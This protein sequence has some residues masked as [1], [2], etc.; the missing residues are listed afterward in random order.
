MVEGGYHSVVALVLLGA[1]WLLVVAQLVEATARIGMC[2]L[3]RFCTTIFLNNREATN[4]RAVRLPLRR[5][6]DKVVFC[7][8]HSLSGFGLWGL[9]RGN[10]KLLVTYYQHH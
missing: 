6:E 7:L 2:N 8:M 5:I 3:Y 1:Q 9:G 4:E 10:G